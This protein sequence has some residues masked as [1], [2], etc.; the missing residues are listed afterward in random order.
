MEPFDRTTRTAGEQAIA[1]LDVVL[2]DAGL[3]ARRL[4]ADQRGLSCEVGGWPLDVGVCV[5]DGMLR[6]Q[7]E[8]C[9]HGQVD[10]HDLLHDHRKRPF[11]RFSHADGGAVWVEAELPLAA[12]TA[13]LVDA[14]LG[15][16]LEA[17]GVARERARVRTGRAG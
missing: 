6:A 9:G 5:Q 14:M 3:P 12:T 7:A 2:A 1:V 15:A 16:L 4:A 10:P 17:A 11:A 8:V 13:E